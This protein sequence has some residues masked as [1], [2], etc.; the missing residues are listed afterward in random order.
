MDE[1]LRLQRL[2]DLLST[3]EMG[4]GRAGFGPGLV[5]PKLNGS[6]ANLLCHLSFFTTEKE[7]GRERRQMDERGHQDRLLNSFMFLHTFTN[8]LT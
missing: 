5:T 4:S 3:A 6:L 7:T 8:T 1:K 2:S